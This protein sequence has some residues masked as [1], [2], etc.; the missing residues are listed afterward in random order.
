[1]NKIYSI[2]CYLTMMPQFI[3][4]QCAVNNTH[5]DPD[6]SHVQPA[7]SGFKTN[8]FKWWGDSYNQIGPINK[9]ITIQTQTPPY[10]VTSPFYSAGI[11]H[12][13]SIVNKP[14][15]ESRP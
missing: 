13:R 11:G 14:L 6:P 8:I 12:L 2:F 15:E 4:C 7:N 5:T 1:M 3:Y 9:D 10:Y